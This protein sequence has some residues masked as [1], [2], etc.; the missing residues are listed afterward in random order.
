MQGSA[1]K[2]TMS[3]RVPKSMELYGKAKNLIP[4]LTQLLSRHPEM[5]A[6]GTSPIYASRAKGCRFWDV[7]GY[8]YI[9]TQGGTGVV[10]IGYCVEEIDRPAKEQLDKG[11]CYV[12]NSPLELEF[13][14]ILTRVIP[15]AEMVRYAKGGGEADCMAIRI[16]RA[17][18][19]RD[20]I[21]FC[22]YHG[23]HDWYLAANL[24]DAESLD[25]HLR[26]GVS[27][28]GVPKVLKGTS[29]PFEYNNLESLRSL[30][31]QN[32]GQVA[33]IIMEACRE[34]APQPGFLE[35]VR[36]L[37]SKHQAV[38]IFDEVVTG[39]RW[40]RGGAQEYFGVTPDV[41]VLG[42]AIANGYP[43][44][45]VVGKREIMMAVN[46]TF[47][48]SSN[49]SETVSLAAGIAIQ[50]FMDEHDFVKHLWDTG[51][52]YQQQLQ[53]IS[54]DA[55]LNISFK[56]YPPVFSFDFGEEDHKAVDTLLTQ[57]FA[58]RGVFGGTHTYMMYALKKSDIDQVLDAF[59]EIVPILKAAIHDGRM[60]ELLEAPVGRSVFKRRLV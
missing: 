9:D 13:A 33:A 53:R 18:T 27:A 35:G 10:S 45:A 40:A 59:K 6:L 34:K 19:G 4:R 31:Q 51:E 17:Y 7:D 60:D 39:F 21:A 37:A 29:I 42:K 11:I 1:E 24:A 43:L 58:K 54:S 2:S 44:A 25:G 57:E 41:T 20:K 50:N 3:T 38:L 48:S 28:A 36:E 30:L 26:P 14:E 15:S 46:D 5:K 55:G 23:W 52:Y 12:V 47:M 56:G 16:A 49:W 32:E 22:G 8:E